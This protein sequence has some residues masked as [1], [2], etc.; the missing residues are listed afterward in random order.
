MEKDEVM[1]HAHQRLFLPVFEQVGKSKSPPCSCEKRKDKDGAPLGCGGRA[2]LVFRGHLG[3]IDDQDL[4]RVGCWFQ[5]QAKLL[6]N[7]G[8]EWRSGSFR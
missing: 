2:Y 3:V 4:H 8:G 1:V 6:L 5:L 7:C